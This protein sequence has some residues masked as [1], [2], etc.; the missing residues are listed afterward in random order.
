MKIA[1]LRLFVKVV[2][3]GSFT[4][5][6]TSLDLP[7][8]NVSRRISELE[9][10]VGTPLFH[11]TTRKISLTNQGE[12]YYHKLLQ[13]IELFDSANEEITQSSCAMKGKVKLGI[14]SE[15]NEKLQPIL[16]QF[17]QQYPDVELDLRVIQNGFTDM[18]QQGLDIAFHGG[19]LVDSSE[20]VARKILALDRCV[21]ASQSYLQKNGTPFT[22]DELAQ[23]QALCYRWPSGDLEV[24]WHFSG[25][26]VKVNSR[27]ESNS[28]A[29]LKDAA[30]SGLGIAF[31][32][33]VLVSSEL[34]TGSLVSILEH[35]LPIAEQG[36]LLYPQ[37]KTLNQASRE[38]IQFL[39]QEV[40]KLI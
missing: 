40:P 10:Q 8:A 2:E 26:T 19:E 13:V 32:P 24:K 35:E 36:Y 3:L 4:A 17:L 16:F 12:I 11:R 25:Q 14:L 29:F 37:P 9:Q 30:K 33:K 39:L 21:V 27:L 38:L 31:L 23:H 6:A 18:Y 5:A 22:V 20:L 1:D 34:Q 28:I 7:R 15:T